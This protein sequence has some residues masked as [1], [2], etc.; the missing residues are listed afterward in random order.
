MTVPELIEPVLQWLCRLNRLVRRG[1]AVDLAA[2]RNEVRGLLADGRSHATRLGSDTLALFESVEPAVT[3]FV[4]A[5][6]RAMRPGFAGLWKSLATERG[7]VSGPILIEQEAQR[8]LAEAAQPRAD[9]RLAVLGQLLALGVPGMATTPAAQEKTSQLLIAISARLGDAAQVD[10][11][12]R[13]CPEAY[14]PLDTRT[15]TQPPAR[16][17]AKIGI[18]LA[19]MVL[20]VILAYF[21]L[22]ARASRDLRSTL[23][24]LSSGAETPNPPGDAK[25]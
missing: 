3:V 12:V 24:T 19:G 6:L 2:A 10:Q 21:Q 9:E 1:A 7:I 4:D 5:H 22:F 25:P 17:L 15:L 14:T 8:A 18:A 16:S 23:T 20:V 11:T 13:L